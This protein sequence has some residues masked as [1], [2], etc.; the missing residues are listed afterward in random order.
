MNIR[1]LLDRPIAFHRPFVTITKS[2]TAA[3]MLSQAVYWAKRGKTHSDGDEWFYKT[4]AEWEEETGLSRTEQETARKKLRQLGILKEKKAGLP[5][6]IFFSVDFDVLYQILE[7]ATK[8]AGILQPR[9]QESCEQDC[10]KPANST[11]GNP[12]PNTETT[13][14]TTTEINTQPAAAKSRYAFEGEVIRLN[15]KDFNQWQA[16]FGD[17]DLVQELN[18]F[19]IEL[20]KDGTKNWFS[21]VSAK[22][23]YQN[24]MARKRKQQHPQTHQTQITIAQNG[25]VFL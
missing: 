19:D 5:A 23:N 2:V 8:D 21:K 10:G 12:Q 17:I 24:E 20:S 18:R 16:L 9:E 15:H 11:A 1:E 22:L 7:D 6:K 4:Q 13:T 3:L 25:L 14:E